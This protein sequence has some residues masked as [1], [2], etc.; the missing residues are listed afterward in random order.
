MSELPDNQRVVVTG[1]GAVTP[2]GMDVDSFFNGLLEGKNGISHVD[3]FDTEKFTCKIGGQ[4]RDF[5]PTVAMDPKEARRND[6]FVQFTMAAAKEAVAHS[7]IDFEK[8][9]PDRVGVFVGSGIGGMDT[10]EKNAQKLLESG[11]RKVSPFLIPALISNMASGVI[12]IEYGAMGPNFS[13]VSACATG[14]HAIGEALKTLRL[15]E[16]DV[17]ICG[18]SEASITPLAFA[19][20]CSMKAMSTNND[21]PK[22][23]SRPFDAGRDGFV[24]GEGAG[25]LV[26]E[27][28]EHAKARGADIICEIAGY[29]AS[30]D[31]N[32][33]TAPHPEGKGLISAM[34]RALNS[35]KIN[36]DQIDYINAHGTSTPYND[37]FETAAVRGLYGD[38]A[39]KL[40]MSSTKSMTG[41]LLGAAG[42]IE[43]V[44]CAKMLQ[45]GKVAPT[46]NL[47]TPDPDCDLDYV[48]NEAREAKLSVT[49]SNSLGFGGQNASLIFKT[50]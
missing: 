49:M 29:G 32:H 2:I 21:D 35:A 31:A 22:G 10:M 30:C 50:L 37:K 11:P 13:I 20:F 3:A 17:M 6:R 4:I 43:S 16:A 47:S 8:E 15:G 38:H 26:L 18:G 25:I 7:G 12:A 40:M 28:L 1:L 24:M 27:T 42:G 5:D 45:A 34:K 23:A 14:A 39:N 33:I 19:G 46:I 9:D 41:H 36:S 44:A 48:P